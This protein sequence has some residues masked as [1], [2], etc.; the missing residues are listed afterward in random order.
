MK[1]LPQNLIYLVTIL[2]LI[3]FNLRA[4][5]PGQTCQITGF[6]GFPTTGVYNCDG[7]CDLGGFLGYVDLSSCGS[8]TDPNAL[9]FDEDAN[10]DDGSCQYWGDEC[11]YTY[12]VTQPFGPTTLV[13]ANGYL[14]CNGQ[15]TGSY[16]NSCA[17]C[18]DPYAFNY[19]EDIAIDDGSC[20][21][22]VYGCT[23]PDAHNYN[24]AANTDDDSCIAPLP[25]TACSYEYIELVPGSQQINYDSPQ[26]DGLPQYGDFFYGYYCRPLVESTVIAYGNYN[27]NGICISDYFQLYGDGNCNN[28]LNCV[29]TGYDAGDC[30]P[31]GCTDTSAENY[32]P[33][34]N[35]DDGSCSYWQ[36]LYNNL[37]I[38][39]DN[40]TPEDGISQADV[41]AIQAVLES[42]NEAYDAATANITDL[43]VQLAIAMANQE[44]GVSQADVDAVATELAATQTA[45]AVAAA[46][47]AAELASV[48]NEL[49]IA[50][51]DI[52]MYHVMWTQA[53]AEATA[54]ADAAAS[55]ATELA[56]VENELMMAQNDAMMYHDMYE[57]TLI[58]CQTSIGFTYS[59]YYLSLPQGWSIFGY[60]CYEAADVISSLSE[61]QDQ[62]EI[63]KDD[64]GMAYIP[65]WGFNAIGEFSY[66]KGYQIK[67]FN[68]VNGFQFCPQIITD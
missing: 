30:S 5:T 12:E 25:G 36:E 65:D 45:A 15:C 55:A 48:E 52:I 10:I 53:Q 2:L 66:G 43:E 59:D 14:S 62:I 51:D 61:I 57:E 50:Q 28:E 27:C 32:N 23:D 33:Y 38:D 26:C 34:A 47:A 60:T 8:C 56:S 4:Q 42:A 44:D 29:F 21:E 9:N 6:N 7:E 46:A 13:T 3:S 64:W 31:F 54:A 41:D 11:T 20:I 49:M 40:I 63:V 19:N 18:T 39:F 1:T 35:T 58:N 22:I 67:L 68:D 37:Q 16:D 24:S 17:G